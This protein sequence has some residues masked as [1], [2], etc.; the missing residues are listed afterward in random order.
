MMA[1]RLCGGEAWWWWAVVKAVEGV[2]ASS[3]RHVAEL[4]LSYMGSLKLFGEFGDWCWLDRGRL[5]PNARLLVTNRC[6][7]ALNIKDPLVVEIVDSDGVE[8]YER[9]GVERVSECCVGEDDL[10]YWEWELVLYVMF[11]EGSQLG[12][13]A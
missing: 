2:V 7:E 5:L 4:W 9:D 13:N 6:S 10:R 11:L 12:D 8:L 3:S 1:G